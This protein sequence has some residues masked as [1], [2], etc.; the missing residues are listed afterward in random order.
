VQR[1]LMC[2]NCLEKSRGADFQSVFLPLIS[3]FFWWTE[4]DYASAMCY[5]VWAKK[6]WDFVVFWWH[7]SYCVSTQYKLSCLFSLP[8]Y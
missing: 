5:N 1:V 6:G 7:V 8:L 2:R 4:L 3:P